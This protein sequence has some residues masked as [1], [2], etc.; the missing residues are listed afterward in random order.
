METNQGVFLRISRYCKVK[1][2]LP[3]YSDTT[4]SSVIY[5]TV[6]LLYDYRLLMKTKPG[7]LPTHTPK[8]STEQYQ[9]HEIHQNIRTMSSKN[10]M[11]L[12]NRVLAS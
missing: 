1:Q 3:S 5:V 4:L 9:M 8:K 11:G 6:Y 7:L 10:S 12:G 2:E